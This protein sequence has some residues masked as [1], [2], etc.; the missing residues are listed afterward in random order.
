MRLIDRRAK[1]EEMIGIL[2]A[3]ICLGSVCQVIYIPTPTTF[4]CT[5]RYAALAWIESNYPEWHVMEYKC[6]NGRN[7]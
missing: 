6:E 3:T 5:E 4:Q 2:Y 7:A 1:E